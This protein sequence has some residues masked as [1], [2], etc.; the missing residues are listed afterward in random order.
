VP[1]ILRGL[2]TAQAFNTVSVKSRIEGEIT[3]INF[4]EG[5]EVHAGDVLVELDA[6]P[7]EAALEEAKST[8]A[9]NRALLANAQLDLQRYAKLLPEHFAPEQQ[10]A[11]QK[12]TV[13]QDE[14]TVQN[15]QAAV[16]AAQL[17][18]EYASIKS[19]IDGVT[20]IRQVDIGNLIQANSQTLVVVT[21]IKPI[22]AIF[23]LPEADIRRIREAMANAKLSVLAFSAS[24]EKQLAEGSLNLIDNTVDQTT[25]TFKLKAEFQN[26]DGALWPGEFINAH[27]VLRTVHN[28]VV[29]PAAVIQTGAKGSYVYVVKADS[30]V[31]MRSVKVLQTENN[32]SLVESGLQAGEQVVTAGQFKLQQGVKVRVTDELANSVSTG[33]SDTPPG[34]DSSQ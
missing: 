16:D 32:T 12:S 2:G 10:Y 33:G 3:K 21:Q 4:A 20:G 27:L 22:Y 17:N 5:Q 30:T 29:V 14:A 18:V 23:T 8:L 28:G 11:T 6:R 26:T 9:R 25:G 19:P 31:D 24:D 7:Y 13:A 15:N 34:I 1:I